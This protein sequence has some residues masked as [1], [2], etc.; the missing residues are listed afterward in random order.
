MYSI[1][2]CPRSKHVDEGLARVGK[3]C[4]VRV[5]AVRKEIVRR[6][7]G[8]YRQPVMIHA[9]FPEFFTLGDV[10][11]GTW[12]L[13][14]HSYLNSAHTHTSSLL[15]FPLYF[16]KLARDDQQSPYGWMA[17]MILFIRINAY[18]PITFRYVF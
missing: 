4:A 7:R 16:N 9:I 3:Q 17:S 11:P 10:G 1:A 6:K 13:A 2:G 12:P 8:V 18:L 15:L 14:I 5:R